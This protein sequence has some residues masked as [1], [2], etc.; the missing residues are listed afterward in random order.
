M[1]QDT[2]PTVADNRMVVPSASLAVDGGLVAVADISTIMRDAGLDSDYRI[3]GGVAV[4]LHGLRTGADV[5]IRT[6]ADAD[7]GVLPK[8]LLQ[9]DLVSR[10]EARGYHKASGCRWERPI[11]DHRTAVVDLLVPAYTSRARASRQYGNVN[12]TE[13]VGLADAF[14]ADPC[15]VDATFILSTGRR[16]AAQVVLPDSKS[17][18]L[19]KAGA[20]AARH[21]DR[22]A[23]QSRPIPGVGERRPG[24]GSDHSGAVS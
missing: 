18:L 24:V 22:D 23:T 3:I 15:V 10:I 19:I 6:T 1:T 5:P 21:E 13:V 17:L 14:Q 7:Y 8:V 9:S 2:G 20:R 4:M 16:L 11:D 12:T